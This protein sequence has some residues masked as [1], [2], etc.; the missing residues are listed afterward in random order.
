MAEERSVREKNEHVRSGTE[1]GCESYG[2][3][4]KTRLIWEKPLGTKRGYLDEPGPRFV[5]VEG[6]RDKEACRWERSQCASGKT[7]NGPKSI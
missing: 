7:A 6:E 5:D 4:G 3:S 1:S 2:R